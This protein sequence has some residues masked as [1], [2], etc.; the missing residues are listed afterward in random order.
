[1][2]T[3]TRNWLRAAAMV[4]APVA[5]LAAFLYHPYVPGLGPAPEAV[6]RTAAAD[7]TRWAASHLL[8][9]AAVA[10]LVL[11]F[12]GLRG[13]LRAT[14]GERW[15][16]FAFPLIIVSGV[17]LAAVPAM[18]LVLAPAA[19]AGADT[20]ALAAALRPWSLPLALVGAIAFLAAVVA[21]AMG[22][23][24]SGILDRTMT[25]LVAIALVVMAL[26][27]VSSLFAA[28]YVMGAASVV[29]FWPL[30][31]ATVRAGPKQED[32]PGTMSDPAPPRPRSSGEPR[33][34][35]RDFGRWRTRAHR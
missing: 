10:L 27:V 5:L 3:P 31:W 22:V 11:A 14:A 32:R 30:A 6:A 21:F 24:R 15:S 16:A 4:I 26:A 35:L 23:A 9:I 33:S 28:F 19:G 1:M 7:P 17:L 2:S 20:A 29:A 34:G 25:A 8:V 12:Q 13:R 18:N